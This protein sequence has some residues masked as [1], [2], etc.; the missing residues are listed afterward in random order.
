MQDKGSKIQELCSQL[1]DGE[2]TS[3][4]AFAA[5]AST[6]INSIGVLSQDDKRQFDTAFREAFGAAQSDASLQK[7][8]V[9]FELKDYFLNEQVFEISAQAT[10]QQIDIAKIEE[11]ELPDDVSTLEMQMAISG[12][13]N[14]LNTLSDQASDGGNDG[15][16]S[17]NTDG[18][19]SDNTGANNT[20]N[21]GEGS[22]G[23]ATDTANN[24]ATSEGGSNSGTTG[25]TTSD[26]EAQ[27]RI[28]PIEQARIEQQAT[29]Q[30]STSQQ[31]LSDQQRGGLTE[32]QLQ[33]QVQTQTQSLQAQR[34]REEP[35]RQERNDTVVQGLEGAPVLQAGQQFQGSALGAQPSTLQN[36]TLQPQGTG[37]QGA[38]QS[39]VISNNPIGNQATM[40]QTLPQGSN[41]QNVQQSTVVQ[42]Q[43]PLAQTQVPIAQPL[44]VD[45]REQELREQAVAEDERLS[46]EI[47]EARAKAADLQ[48]VMDLEMAKIEE[49][50]REI[51]E[52]EQ[53]LIATQSELANKEE[54]FNALE[55][56]I[57]REEAERHSIDREI[58]ELAPQLDVVKADL[59]QWQEEH[60]RLEKAGNKANDQLGELEGKKSD[61]VEKLTH[62]ITQ[63]KEKAKTTV[64]QLEQQKENETEA[65]NAE[66]LAYTNENIDPMYGMGGGDISHL[67]SAHQKKIE[68]LDKKIIEAR[69]EA[70]SVEKENNQKISEYEVQ[71]TAAKKELEV[72]QSAI[73]EHSGTKEA[74]DSRKENATQKMN[75]Y[76]EQSQAKGRGIADLVSRKEGIKNELSGLR[77]DVEQ[78]QNKLKG[79]EEKLQELGG[80]IRNL[81]SRRDDQYRAERQAAQAREDARAAEIRRQEDG[82]KQFKRNEIQQKILSETA[83]KEEL[84][85]VMRAEFALMEQ[86]TGEFTS[87]NQ[88]YQSLLN[89]SQEVNRTLNDAI[90]SIPERVEELGRMEEQL[91][92]M[93]SAF[94]RNGTGS[95][96]QIDAFALQVEQT[97][98]DL[99]NLRDGISN[100]QAE[101]ARL[102]NQ[103]SMARREAESAELKLRSFD[104]RFDVLRKDIADNS[105]NIEK[106]QT[107][108]VDLDQM[109]YRTWTTKHELFGGA[110][111]DEFDELLSN[112]NFD[113]DDDREPQYN[114]D[115]LIANIEQPQQP[116][117]NLQPQRDNSD[118]DELLADLGGGDQRENDDE[119]DEE[120]R[121]QMD[122]VNEL[123]DDFDPDLDVPDL[124]EDIDDDQQVQQPG[125][126]QPQVDVPVDVNQRPAVPPVDLLQSAAADYNRAPDAINPADKASVGQALLRAAGSTLSYAGLSPD[127]QKAVDS[128][129][130]RKCKGEDGQIDISKIPAAASSLVEQAYYGYRDVENLNKNYDYVI[131]NENNRKAINEMFENRGENQSAFDGKIFG[132]LNH[133]LRQHAPDRGA[134][135]KFAGALENAAAGIAN[136][137]D[138]IGNAF[139]EHPVK[140]AATVSTLILIGMMFIPGGFAMGLLVFAAITGSAGIVSLGTDLAKTGP[141]K[142]LFSLPSLG[143]DVLMAAAKG[144]AYLG[145]A[146]YCASTGKTFADVK[147]YIDDM[148][149]NMATTKALWEFGKE[150]KA[151][152]KV[153]QHAKDAMENTK[154]KA[155]DNVVKALEKVR[156]E[157]PEQYNNKLAELADNNPG[158]AADQKFKEA[159][160][161]K[162]MPSIQNARDAIAQADQQALQNA[163]VQ[164]GHGQDNAGQAVVP[165]QVEQEG[166]RVR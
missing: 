1:K 139:K 27:G 127:H 165:V 43:A 69:K 19:G 114:L 60:T 137:D 146:A 7:I 105:A 107:Q 2:A 103:T 134:W 147:D 15:S 142:V 10:D 111:L 150:N 24:G 5:N 97:R 45:P 76:L 57:A 95:Q 141:G 129:V 16:G 51:K 70:A 104:E 52:D 39:T 12:H 89:R 159:L 148:I 29:I 100:L 164:I 153:E 87:K 161:T 163:V 138:R 55:S 46:R 30:P 85:V 41:L 98:A 143:I 128:I 38:P 156:T 14:T 3:I 58:E 88:E 63:A 126:V 22:G 31:S 18:S 117:N 54:A 68:E 77:S 11:T 71:I 40:A 66:V 65:Y 154:D 151:P 122:Q 162:G 93:K 79:K 81:E 28:R 6:F 82:Q 59:E 26:S 96:D 130:N 49:L 75:D 90:Q 62:E 102:E 4:Q 166:Q 119:M 44:Q 124:F 36:A 101:S 72:A 37:A 136:L 152:Y 86:L 115:D 9:V 42:P 20:G 35:Q 33:N 157:T 92:N 125:Q 78:K 133:E 123:D 144:L 99:S 74:L 116:V 48:R 23:G 67:E 56:E 32:V 53:A 118:L 149:P 47:E 64:A 61:I 158:L 140:S 131:N 84:D 94:E 121:A 145:G 25:G 8:K 50:K 120:L 135:K 106:W 80:A 21:T 109:D 13:I 83:K 112:P 17:S 108:L 91:K 113:I 160:Q 110:A 132:A 73:S 34:V 155:I